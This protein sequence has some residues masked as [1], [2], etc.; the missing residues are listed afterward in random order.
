M[1]NKGGLTGLRVPPIMLWRVLT[2]AKSLSEPLMHPPRTCEKE[3]HQVLQAG[4]SNL[5]INFSSR[6]S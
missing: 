1:N 6:D 2:E 5:E 4:F 3:N